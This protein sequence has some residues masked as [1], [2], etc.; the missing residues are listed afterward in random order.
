VDAKDLQER[1]RRAVAALPRRYRVIVRRHLNGM[2]HA[3]IATTL[4]LP[5]RTVYNRFHRAKDLLRHLLAGV[6]QLSC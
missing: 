2:S 1:V 5:I 3:Q 4:A 6:E